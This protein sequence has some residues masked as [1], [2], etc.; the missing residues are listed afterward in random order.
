MLIVALKIGILAFLLVIPIRLFVAQ[1]FLVSG[2]SMQPSFN[3]GDYLVIDRL[4]Y[5]FAE[6]ERGDV[7]VFRYPLDPSHFF[8]K[9]VVDLPGETINENTGALVDPSEATSTSPNEPPPPNITLARDE[10]FVLGDNR[11]D[12]TDS[13]TW[14]P[15]QKKFIIGRVV[16]RAWPL[17]W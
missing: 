11:A 6:P 12:S 4:A 14:G 8:I 16:F 15:L 9:R 2:V 5:D 1:P 17:S 3:S 10:Y 13:R 7:I